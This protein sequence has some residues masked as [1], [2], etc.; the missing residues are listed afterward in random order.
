MRLNFEEFRDCQRLIEDI[1]NNT[2]AALPTFFGRL[3]YLASLRDT[4]TGH[5]QHYGL[6]RIYGENV[7]QRGLAFCHEE[8]FCRILEMPLEEQAEDLR[9]FLSGLDEPVEGVVANWRELEPYRL[10]VPLGAQDSLRRLFLSDVEILLELF[11]CDADLI[12]QA[13]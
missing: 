9:K 13:A 2:L 7:L 12:P 3:A 4:V 6:E 10:W 1:S 8:L 5:Y 11:T